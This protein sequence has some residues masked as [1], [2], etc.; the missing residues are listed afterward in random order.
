[1]HP[2]SFKYAHAAVNAG[3]QEAPEGAPRVWIHVLGTLAFAVVAVVSIGMMA[4][5]GGTSV[6][7]GY[8][9]GVSNANDTVS[10]RGT[11][12]STAEALVPVHAGVNVAY[13]AF[14]WYHHAWY[15]GLFK[16]IGWNPLAV[17]KDSLLVMPL[18]VAQVALLARIA[19]VEKVALLVFLAM[20]CGFI[21]LTS[22]AAAFVYSVV[23][24]K[25][26]ADYIVGYA[27]IGAYA[28]LA[29]GAGLF[30]VQWMVLL[31]NVSW[32]VHH[33]HAPDYTVAVFLLVMIMF[34]LARVYT[35]YR[36]K[37][38]AGS[39]ERLVALIPF[40]ITFVL[41]FISLPA[42]M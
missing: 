22:E 17:V 2:S 18:M 10:I 19:D 35:F 32:Q 20:A 27:K 12:V 4:S 8:V 24:E 6:D 16:R 29:L 1:M 33:G 26:R 31:T 21:D 28:L 7:A 36:V 38:G 11:S 37:T 15:E 34:G 9:F 39:D 3:M 40:A 13:H 30:V 23:G 41:A 5:G 42:T 25:A 14:V